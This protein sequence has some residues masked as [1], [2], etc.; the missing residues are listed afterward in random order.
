VARG[1]ALWTTATTPRQPP[2]ATVSASA[3]GAV[4]PKMIGGVTYFQLED[5]LRHCLNEGV[6][7]KVYLESCSADAASELIKL[8][9]T[10]DNELE[11][12]ADSEYITTVDP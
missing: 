4:N 3:P 5:P 8:T 10:N 9:G 12:K 6:A 7:G 11:F 1:L 2:S